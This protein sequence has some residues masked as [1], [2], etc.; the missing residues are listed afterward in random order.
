[1]HLIEISPQA[2]FSGRSEYF[3]ALFRDHFSET[4]R[5]D[6]YAES[7]N[8]RDEEAVKGS[9]IDRLMLRNVTADVKSF[10]KMR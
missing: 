10:E 2:A 4:S 6:F 1:M 5:T 9:G 7:I 3:R 8:P